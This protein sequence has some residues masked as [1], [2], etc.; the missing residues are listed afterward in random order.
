MKKLTELFARISSIT[1]YS[2]SK[3][4]EANA[5]R[6]WG[7]F[8]FTI[9]DTIT[10]AALRNIFVGELTNKDTRRWAVLEKRGDKLRCITR[11]ETLQ[12]ALTAV[13]AILK[14]EGIFAFSMESLAK[15]S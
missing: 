6:I 3:D 1:H 2:E 12:D 10:G 14:Q 7:G 11:K 9:N 4:L 5:N 13:N 8:Q 15:L